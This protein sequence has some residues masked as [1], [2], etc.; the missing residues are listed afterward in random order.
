VQ[1]LVI[2]SGFL[3]VLVVVLVAAQPPSPP[4][5]PVDPT[6]PVVPALPPAGPSSPPKQSLVP[7]SSPPALLP[8]APQTWGATPLSR[9]ESLV[10]FPELTRS[11]L[12]GVLIGAE[13]MVKDNQVNGRFLYGYIPALRLPM[14]EDND[15]AQARAA[16]A[17]AQAAHFSGDEKQTAIASQAILALV[18][19]TRTAPNDPNCRVPVQASFTCNRVGFA[20]LLAMA[21]YELPNPADKLTDDAER[22]CA[23]LRGQIRPDGSVH[24]TDGATDVPTQID[25]AGVYEYPGLAL[26]TLAVSNRIRPAAWKKDALTRGI[27]YYAALFHSKPNPR[28]AATVVPA[29][30]E[31]YLQTKTNEAASAVFE[32]ADWLCDL[33]IPLS[34]PRT[35]QWA[36]GFRVLNNGRTTGDLLDTAETGMCLQSLA[37]AYQLTHMTGD[38]TREAKYRSALNGTVQYLCG[39]QFVEANTRHFENAFRTSYLIGGFHLSPTDGTLRVDATACAVSGLLR[40]LSSGAERGGP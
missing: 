5:V 22:L 1:R 14:A 30:S 32:M 40:F 7:S 6:P 21:I 36:G 13:R 9:F 12:G 39:L 3:F 27:A 25:P 33:Q 26:H 16:V 8:T 31:L 28:L 29:A 15:L 19:A 10:A 2:L 35:L 18:A 37:G 34:D 20:A 24:Y 38:L 23:F 4:V 11:A 17:M